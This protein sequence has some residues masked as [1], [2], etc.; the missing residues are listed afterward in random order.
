MY[1][2]VGF[3]WPRLGLGGIISTHLWPPEGGAELVLA[4]A[5]AANCRYPRFGLILAGF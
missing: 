1:G 2:V 4:P 3:D 5:A